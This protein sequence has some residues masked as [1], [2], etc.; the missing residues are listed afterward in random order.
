MQKEYQRPANVLDLATR[1]SDLGYHPIPIPRG[2]KGPTISG[3]QNLRISF[4]NVE[5]F[6]DDKCGVGILQTN[7]MVID[8]DVYDADLAQKIIEEGIRRFPKALERIGQA[9][10]SALFLNMPAPFEI[11]NTTKGTKD[12]QTAQV[13]VRSVT[14]QVVAYGLHPETNQTYKWPRGELWA[15]KREDLETAT[16]E[17]VQDFRDWCDQQIRDWA[18]IEEDRQPTLS[19]RAAANVVDFGTLSRL[20]DDKPSE[21]EFREALKYIPASVGYDDWLSALMGIHD[22]YDG[23]QHGLSVAQDWSAPYQ[24]YNPKEVET[25]WKSFE[26]G[27]GTGYRSVLHMA[28]L[29]GCDLSAIK[30]RDISKALTIPPPIPVEQGSCIGSVGVSQEV[31]QPQPQINRSPLE[32]FNDIQPALDSRYLIKGVLDDGAMSVIYGPSN[33]GKTFFA[34]DMAFHMA[35]GMQWRNRRTKR[36]SVLYLATEGGRGVQNRMA[37]L[38]QVHGE[39]DAV[40]ALRRAGLD[41]LKQEADLQ[42]VLDLATEV[43]QRGEGQPLVVVIDTLSRIMAGGDENSAAD[44]TA[45]IRNIDA[46]REAIQCHIVLVHHTGKDTARGARGHSSLRAATDTEI[47]VGVF[48]EEDDQARAA[49]VTKQRDNAGGETFAFDLRSISLGIDQDGDEVSSCVIETTDEQE[50]RAAKAAKKGLGGNQKIIADT[51]DQLVGEGMWQPN[52]GGV[53]FPEPGRY[54]CVKLDDLRAHSQGKFDA[55]NPR[56]AWKSAWKAISEKRGLFC[57]ASDL[58]WRVDRRNN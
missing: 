36:C 56:D 53:G 39:Q 21:T 4:D 35:V 18:G 47:E 58:V 22:Y 29:H 54:P 41:L 23:S 8:I 7:I 52:P 5:K 28:K 9:P 25:K 50:F 38:K 55:A 34:L 42:H 1:I 33:S 26:P 30:Q 57:I 14:G 20:A 31:P 24:D 44:M 13:E 15:T 37:A 27:K 3:W 16:E 17:Q 19:E 48:G 12:G 45:L 46:I 2:R 32:Y 40:F 11:Q 10:K 51:F 43:K 49:M 6:F